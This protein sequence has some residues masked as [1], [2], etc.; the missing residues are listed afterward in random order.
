[1]SDKVK[2]SSLAKN[3]ILSSLAHALMTV[4]IGEAL[5]QASRLTADFASEGDIV[6]RA[7]LAYF[8]PVLAYWYREHTQY[9]YKMLSGS[10]PETGLI[11]TFAPWKWG[12]DGFLDWVAPVLVLILRVEL[13][14]WL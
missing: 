6:A 4:V 13:V 12:L 2:R 1:M 7:F 11:M 8:A 5:F 10:V 14:Y 3:P 9:E